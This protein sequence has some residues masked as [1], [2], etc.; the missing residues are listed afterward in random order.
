MSCLL[1]AV[2]NNLLG[3]PRADKLFLNSPL[4]LRF[5]LGFFGLCWLNTFGCGEVFFQQ[6][7]TTCTKKPCLVISGSAATLRLGHRRNICFL[8]KQWWVYK[9]TGF[10]RERTKSH[11]PMGGLI[12]VGEDF[13]KTKL[14]VSWGRKIPAER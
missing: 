7:T 6:A 2:R 8:T 5:L 9:A 4:H 1:I 11:G 12:M 10:C 3:A 14:G 13:G